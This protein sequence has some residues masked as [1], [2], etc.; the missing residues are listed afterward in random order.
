MTSLRAVGYVTTVFAIPCYSRV[1]ILREYKR[2]KT[3]MDFKRNQLSSQLELNYHPMDD[4]VQKSGGCSWNITESGRPWQPPG[5]HHF[6]NCR[7][8][9]QDAMVCV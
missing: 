1:L 2:K 3:R 4:L 9:L 6:V 8:N 5:L 7:G